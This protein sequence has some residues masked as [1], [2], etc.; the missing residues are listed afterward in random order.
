[1]PSID[2]LKQERD[3][4]SEILTRARKV[5]DEAQDRFDRAYWKLYDAEIRAENEATMDKH[6]AEKRA[7]RQVR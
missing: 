4:A 6:D 7:N 2:K 3:L 5:L 1:L